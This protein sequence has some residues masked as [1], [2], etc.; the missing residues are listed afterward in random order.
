MK[1]KIVD[2]TI[3][4]SAVI[5][6]LAFFYAQSHLFPSFLYEEESEQ[7]MESVE[8]STKREGRY[9]V[10]VAYNVRATKVKGTRNSVMI[11]WD[12]HPE[13]NGRFVL[14]R[15]GEVLD[16]KEKALKAETIKT[17]Q[18]QERSVHIEPGL[19]PGTYFYVILSKDR[20]ASRDVELYAD[21]NYTTYP[22]VIASEKEKGLSHVKGISAKKISSEKVLITWEGVSDKKIIYTVY[23]AR[24]RIA[25][26]EVVAVS[27]RVASLTDA[28]HYIDDTIPVT[29]TYYYAVSTKKLEGREHFVYVPGETYTTNGVFVYKKYSLVIQNIRAEQV[30]NDIRV[31]WDTVVSGIEY[32]VDGYALYRA[33]M[34]VSNYER[35]DFSKHLATL[36]GRTTTYIDRDPG[37]GKHYYAVLVKF[38]NGAVDL[39][40]QPGFNYTTEPIGLSKGE[41]FFTLT[42]IDAAVERGG[43]V[44]SWKY[45]GGREGVSYDLYRS[46]S[47]PE[48]PS[49]V[50]PSMIITRV[51][52]TSGSYADTSPPQG[53]YYYGLIPVHKGAL[54]DFVIQE[55]V[56]VTS[57]PIGYS[58]EMKMLPRDTPRKKQEYSMPG[59]IDEIL[60]RTFFRGR[61]V[62][63]IKE[64]QDLI[65][66]S[67]NT[68]EK[69]KARL[70]IGRS[71][72][73]RG[74]YK[75]ALLFLSLQDVSTYFPEEAEFWHDFAILRVQ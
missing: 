26:D 12:V 3:L 34:P 1:K 37:P 13:F 11:T 61:Y 38:K 2:H 73:E 45:R 30:Q 42:M 36:D 58:T 7:L 74:D 56:N 51:D 22:V 68:I 41:Q 48:S 5:T 64:L 32:E 20:I 40:L 29:G 65:R 63:A 24:K 62:L 18:G 43:I 46:T 39:R 60:H 21:V 54:R 52:L 75:K 69:A 17:V 72:I 9:P 66:T 31:Q 59:T 33:S 23:R 53:M 16:T 55:G 19:P 44:V 50:G 49:A 10:D 8:K 67:D 27:D 35:L 71:Y 25:D 4:M 14:G 15:A 57:Y 28:E 47:I 70:F 6:V